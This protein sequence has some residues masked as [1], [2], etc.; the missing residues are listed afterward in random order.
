MGNT[1]ST[2]SSRPQ[3]GTPEPHLPFPA[4]QNAVDADTDAEVL[5]TLPPRFCILD[6]HSANWL[7]RRVMESRAYAERVKEWAD[8]E[9]RRADREEKTLMYLFGHQIEAWVRSEVE[10]LNGKRK[11]LALPSGTVGFRKSGAKVVV[12]DEKVVLTWAKA[13]CPA[14]VVVVEKL[15]KIIL[16]THI[17]ETGH[18]PDQGIH[19]EPEVEKFYMR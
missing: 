19:I 13:N 14:A 10:K 12:D 16:D 7:V 5:K 1:P 18:C 17:K 4:S 15:A 2:A 8:Q 3:S 9:V 11:S 6:E